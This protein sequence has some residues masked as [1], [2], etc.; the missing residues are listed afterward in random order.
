MKKIALCNI[1]KLYAEINGLQELYLPVRKAGATNFAK[2]EGGV[3]V[4]IKSLQTVKSAK[5]LFFPQSEDMIEFKVN[6]K[7]IEVKDARKQSEPFVLFGVRGCDVKSLEVLDKVFLAE[8]VDSYYKTRREHGVIVA[9][10]CSKPTETCF[11]GTFGV[12]ASA[13]AGDILC[14]KTADAFYLEGQT[15]KVKALLAKLDGVT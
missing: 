2:Y 9:M 15:E 11:C 5:D 14:Y 10:A 7:N 3:E 13:P 4:D 8:P 12:D 1:E 6:G